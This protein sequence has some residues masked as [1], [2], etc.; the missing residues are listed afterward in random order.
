M[1]DGYGGKTWYRVATNEWVCADD[2]NFDGDTDVE[3]KSNG[4]ATDDTAKADTDEVKYYF[5]PFFYYSLAS[6]SKH[7]LIVGEDIT[8]DQIKDA[9]SM[10]KY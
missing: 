3:P 5:D 9:D 2:I 6:R 4:A 10:K 8:N 1:S 7:G